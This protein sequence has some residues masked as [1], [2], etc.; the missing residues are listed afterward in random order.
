ML[1]KAAHS[2]GC[3]VEKERKQYLTLKVLVCQHLRK[4]GDVFE[5]GVRCGLRAGR[6]GQEHSDV[7]LAFQQLSELDLSRS[8]V[9]RN[10]PQPP[11]LQRTGMAPGESRAR[12]KELI[13]MDGATDCWAL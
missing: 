6:A 13:A 7:E 9:H 12:W 2:L 8:V 3:V 11:N 1:L 5:D 4:G 10:A